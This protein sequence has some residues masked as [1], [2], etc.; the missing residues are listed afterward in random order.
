MELIVRQSQVHVTSV[1]DSPERLVE[2]KYISSFV[3]FKNA[4]LKRSSTNLLKGEFP[5][6]YR[7][8]GSTYL[9]ILMR[10]QYL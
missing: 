6:D 4:E 7:G 2:L 8:T 10:P 5:I 3:T 1:V 9:T